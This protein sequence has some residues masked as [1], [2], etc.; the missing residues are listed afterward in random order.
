MEEQLATATAANNEGQLP[1]ATTTASAHSLIGRPSTPVK[2]L[3]DEQAAAAKQREAD[4]EA[5]VAAAQAEAAAQAKAAAQA[6][7]V[8]ATAQAAAAAAAAGPVA[9]PAAG[10]PNGGLTPK[11]NVAYSLFDVMGLDERVYSS[12][13]VKL[14][15]QIRRLA[16]TSA[17]RRVT[18]VASSTCPGLTSNSISG[19]RIL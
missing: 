12:I 7:A 13:Q 9:G 15:Y 10:P 8:A 3:A 19:S 1:Q 16:L 17:L 4:L 2:R 11:P 5:L 14:P 18:S 6:A